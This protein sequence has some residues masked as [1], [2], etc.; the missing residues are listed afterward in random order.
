[1]SNDLQTYTAELDD[2]YAQSI[3]AGQESLFDAAVS[4]DLSKVPEAVLGKAA[5]GEILGK[6]GALAGGAICTAYGAAAIAPLCAAAG[7]WVGKQIVPVVSAI[8]SA[9]WSAVTRDGPSPDWIVYTP[10]VAGL[11]AKREAILSSLALSGDDP[12]T[13]AAI[14]KIADDLTPEY[15]P[16]F[17]DILNGQRVKDLLS[18]PMGAGYSTL[19]IV[20]P[21][22]VLPGDFSYVDLKGAPIDAGATGFRDERKPGWQKRTIDRLLSGYLAGG[23]PVAWLRDKLSQKYAG[24]PDATY[25]GILADVSA[26]MVPEL[27]K[28][29]KARIEFV[30]EESAIR[31]NIR[32]TRTL[33]KIT[34]TLRAIHPSWPEK[35]IV[36]AREAIA[37][38]VKSQDPQ[39][40]ASA[41]AVLEKPKP[42]SDGE[43]T[44]KKA[45]AKAGAGLAVGAVAT[46]VII[47]LMRR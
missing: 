14:R 40:I 23:I 34:K 19:F 15:R 29:A 46:I 26:A 21:Y 8:G 11:R 17:P 2:L 5:S 30:L 27:D 24:N 20:P 12:A 7:S 16:G 35:E 3:A 37:S 43:P 6:A 25:G 1:M 39:A 4:G 33:S 38:A 10:D 42:E 22:D 13:V 28:V 45:K 9:I 31:R 18:A 41:V 44:R 36:K 47:A 32:A